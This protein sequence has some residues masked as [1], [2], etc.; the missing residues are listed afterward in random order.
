MPAMSTETRSFCGVCDRMVFA[1]FT[2]YSADIAVCD[3]CL[4]EYEVYTLQFPRTTLAEFVN[5]KRIT[6]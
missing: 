5:H 3:G 4:R 1:T 6:T 2:E